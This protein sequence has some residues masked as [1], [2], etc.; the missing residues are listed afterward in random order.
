LIQAIR[1]YLILTKPGILFGNTVTAIAGF[2]YASKT[3]FSWMSF[4]SMTIG[5]GLVMASSCVLNNCIDIEADSSM[6]RTKYRPL[7]QGTIQIQEALFFAAGLLILGTNLLYLFTNT[8]ALLFSY[9]GLIFYVWFYTYSK[10]K[11]SYSTWIGSIAGAV[12]PV[13]GYLASNPVIS[14]DTLVLFFLLVFWQI[15]HFYAIAI[16]REKDYSASK[17]LIWNKV[18]GFKSTV[19]QMSICAILFTILS[20]CLKISILLFLILSLFNL[21]FSYLCIYGF[22]TDEVQAWSKKVFRY[23]LILIMSFSILISV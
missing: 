23:S 17:F 6:E 2:L 21:Y 7:V 18:K 5:L 11:T 20:A 19:L 1:S 12:P 15:P 22:F 10:Y 13:V 14:S 8:L 9:F 16:F 3:E 4:I